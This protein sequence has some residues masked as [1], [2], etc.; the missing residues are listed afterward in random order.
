MMGIDLVYM[1]DFREQLADPSSSF[2]AGTFTAA[3][4][5]SAENRPSQDPPRHL[6]ARFAAKE[7]FLKAWD[8]TFWGRHP[9]LERVDLREIEIVCDA[10]GRPSMVLHGAV[11]A[12]LGPDVTANVSMSHDGPNAIAVVALSFQKGELR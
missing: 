2:V 7:A 11:A 9:P 12:R 4:I 1:P 5:A 6:A 3:E 8:S 10:W